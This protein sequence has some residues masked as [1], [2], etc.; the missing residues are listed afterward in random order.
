M[1][2]ALLSEYH[3]PLELIERP[4]PEPTGPR[5]VV[6]QIAGAGVCQTDLHTIDGHMEPAG[7]RLPLVLGHENAGWVHTVGDDV[8]AAAVGDA[9][10]L[11]PPYSCGLCVPCRRGD[12]VFCERHQFTGLTQDGGFADYVVVVERSLL[13]LP[14]GVEPVEVAPHADAG[15]TAY[16]AVKKQVPRLDAGSTTV[17]IGVGGVGHIGLQLVKVLGSGG[18]VIGVDRDERR[19]SLARELGAD[20]VLG[21]EADV[22]GAVRELTD[23][24]G[25][26]VVFDFVGTDATHA[27]GLEM[28]ARRGLFSIVGYGGT[29]TYPSVAL[30]SGETSIAGNLVGN[31]IDLWE[32]LQLHGRGAVTLRSETHPL[33]EVNDVLGALREGEITGRAVLVP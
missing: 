15:I 6:V 16:H 33:D 10:L 13:R 25:A 21:D 31:W 11:Y 3:T 14:P 17:V 19:R 8:T 7:V 32:L 1:R 29:V 23:G 27:L 18:R 26:D 20:E 24:A 22:A 4:D 28:L 12:E 30:V 9:V 2:A 5:S